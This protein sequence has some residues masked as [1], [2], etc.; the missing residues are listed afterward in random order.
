MILCRAFL[1]QELEYV[2]TLVGGSYCG[3]ISYSVVTFTVCLI[4]AQTGQ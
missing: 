2:A 4:I 1:F 3:R